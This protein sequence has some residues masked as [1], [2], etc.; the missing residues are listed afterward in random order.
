MKCRKGGDVRGY[1]IW[2]LMDNFEWGGG[3]CVK[4][5]LYQILRPTLDRIPKLSATWYRD[6]LTNSTSDVDATLSYL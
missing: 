5:G 2:S 3:Y 6:F 4:F 1:F